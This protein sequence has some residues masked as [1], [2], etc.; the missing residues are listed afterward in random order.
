MTRLL[1]LT[2]HLGAAWWRDALV[3]IPVTF[4]GLYALALVLP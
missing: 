1:A 4:G 2:A 3:I